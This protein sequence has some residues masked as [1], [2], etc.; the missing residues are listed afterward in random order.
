[1]NGDE[2][3][4]KF[5]DLFKAFQEGNQ[6]LKNAI[7]FCLDDI[8]I[9]REKVEKIINEMHNSQA[10]KSKPPPV[11]STV[12]AEEDSNHEKKEQESVS[13]WPE[14]RRHLYDKGFL[15][16]DGKRVKSKLY[17]VA[18]EFVLHTGQNATW[19]FLQENFLQPN[20][21]KYSKKACQKAR[22]DINKL[23]ARNNTHS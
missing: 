5:A 12:G 19:S 9:R 1:M 7:N 11:E 22:D 16:P 8:K 14:W 17:D 6:N 23:S 18:E 15:Y 20:G 2:Q 10:E 4:N 21:T 3:S 13:Q